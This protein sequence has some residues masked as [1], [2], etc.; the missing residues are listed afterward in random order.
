M[1]KIELPGV[2]RVRSKGRWYVYAWR[3]GPRILAEP[4]SASFHEE[5]LSAFA[6]RKS[7]EQGRISGLCVDWKRS[8]AWAKLSPS[9]RKNWLRWVDEIQTHFGPLRVQQFDRAEIRRDIKRWR[10]QW[11]STPRAADMAKQVLSALLSFAVEEGRLGS[12]PCFGLSNLYSSNRSE[13]IW[14]DEDIMRL[15]QAAGPELMFALGLACLTGLRRADL[16]R[17]SWSHIGELAIE[18]RTGK[19]GGHKTALVPLYAELRAL[20]D[21]IPKRSTTVLTN[22]EGK[23]WKSGFSSSWN[24]AVRAAGESTLHFHDARGTFATMAAELD[25]FSPREIAEMLGWSDTRV[26]RIVNRYVRQ[27]AILRD[28]IRRMDEARQ[29]GTGT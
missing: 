14:T 8:E 5:L 7:G 19:S 22:S 2:H 27:H 20:L 4:G 11:R 15:A 24:K 25:V 3:G 6:Q 1:A 10:D 21:V 16:L 9:T 17:L 12:N 28:R 13:L 23:P 29:N 18:I 26:E